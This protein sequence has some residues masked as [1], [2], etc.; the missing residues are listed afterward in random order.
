MSPGLKKKNECKTFTS[1]IDLVKL[2][3]V[4][5]AWNSVSSG[6]ICDNSIPT[7][8]ISSRLTQCAFHCQESLSHWLISLIEV[9]PETHLS[10][11]RVC[12]CAHWTAAAAAAAALKTGLDCCRAFFLLLLATFI[13]PHTV[14]TFAGRFSIYSMWNENKWLCLEL[15][16]LC[17]LLCIWPVLVFFLP[18]HTLPPLVPP[19]CI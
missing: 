14:H 10:S 1:F 12:V 13:Q 9:M 11:K 4:T 8:R 16:V 3:T 17:L 19:P 18:L 5:A 2:L 15:T 7:V 6:N